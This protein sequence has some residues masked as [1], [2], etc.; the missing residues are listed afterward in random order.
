MD[1]QNHVDV[2]EK[3]RVHQEES[4][5]SMIYQVNMVLGMRQIIK[6]N[7]ILI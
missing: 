2:Y 5:M 1:S 7:F 4:A 3:K 6:R